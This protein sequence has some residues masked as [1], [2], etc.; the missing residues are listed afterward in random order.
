MDRKTLL[1]ITL[2]GE[3]GLF[4]LGLLLM[5]A[6]RAELWSGF[7]VSRGSTAYA[8]LLCLPMLAVLYF[9]AR[10]RWAPLQRLNREID[11]KVAPI[12]A[13]CKLLD[14][15][16]IAL[17]AG[18]G[19]EL[20]FR[21]WLQAALTNKFDVWVGISIASA[22]FGLAHYLSTAYAVYAGLT[23]LYLGVIYH[24]TGNLYIVMTIHA[25]YDFIALMYLV[26]KGEEET[27]DKLG[28]EEGDH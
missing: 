18:A 26:E 12:F 2:F 28:G 13:N 14:L 19:E 17:L 1:L 3:G 24:V 15:A 16:L 22:I 5:G 21:G 10:S 9:I 11:E 20:F 6:S 23:G 8:L 25:V 4:L 27:G 7:E